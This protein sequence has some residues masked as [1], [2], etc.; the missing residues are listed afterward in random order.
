[1]DP[2]HIEVPAMRLLAHILLLMTAA[3]T[4][5]CRTVPSPAL[6]QSPADR[7]SAD[8]APAECPAAIQ[9]QV[10]LTASAVGRTIPTELA[11]DEAATRPVVARTIELAVLPQAPARG[12]RLMANTLTL[13]TIG[14]TLKGWAAVDSQT[15]VAGRAIDVIPGRLRISPLLTGSSLAPQTTSLD[16]LV[17]PGAVPVDEAAVSAHVLWGNDRR[18]VTTEAL[19]VDLRPLRHFTAFDVVEARIVL[20]FVGAGPPGPALRSGQ[21]ECSAE[22]TVTLVDREAANPA[23]WD[24]RRTAQGRSEQW[25]A[26]F[27]PS[28]GPVRAIFTSPADADSFALWLRQTHATHAGRYQLGLFRPEYSRQPQNTRPAEGSLVNTFQ[29]VSADDLDALIVGRLGQP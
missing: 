16:V 26:L 18:P 9:G 2:Q 4:S 14:G 6:A 13:T 29:P 24:L 17:V 8:E 21:W 12:V 11:V 5:S 1:V 20:T 23:L 28:T 7:S 25:L 19:K 15:D 3:L 27:D 22:T 10:R